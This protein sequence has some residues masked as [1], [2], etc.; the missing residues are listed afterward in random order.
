[1]G[2]TQKRLRVERGKFLDKETK[3]TEER[4]LKLGDGSLGRAERASRQDAKMPRKGEKL[5]VGGHCSTPHKKRLT[6]GEILL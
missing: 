2:E 6:K 3:G 5:P 4:S 1:M